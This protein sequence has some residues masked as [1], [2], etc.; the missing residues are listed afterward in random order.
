MPKFEEGVLQNEEN[1]KKPIESD[2]II[3]KLGGNPRLV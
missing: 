3:D 1:W 2:V